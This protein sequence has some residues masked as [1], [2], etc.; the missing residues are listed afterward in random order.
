MS[1]VEHFGGKEYPEG[2]SSGP[3]KERET[4]S[5]FPFLKGPETRRGLDPVFRITSSSIQLGIFQPDLLNT[6]FSMMAD[7]M[8]H[9]DWAKGCPDSW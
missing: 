6:Y 5:G 1:D 7:C 8:R 4:L 3:G 2:D 9:L